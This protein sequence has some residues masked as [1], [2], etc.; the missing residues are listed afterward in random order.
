MFFVSE[1]QVHGNQDQHSAQQSPKKQIT[2][3]SRFRYREQEQTRKKKEA[4]VEIFVHAG[5][6]SDSVFIIA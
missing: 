5:R 6:L 1:Y 2:Q 4:G 3:G